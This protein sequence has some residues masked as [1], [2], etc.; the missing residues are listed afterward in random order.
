TVAAGSRRTG[1]THPTVAGSSACC[2]AACSAAARPHLLPRFPQ[3]PRHPRTD[4]DMDKES[5]D[6]VVVGAGSAGSVIA[7]RLSADPFVRVCLVEAGGP[8]TSSLIHAPSGLVVMMRSKINNWALETV[9][10]PGLNG[11]TGYQPRGKTL[12]GSSS[13]NGMV[14][15]RGHR[16]DYDHWASLGNDGW[17]FSQVLPY[18]RRAENSEVYGEN[19]YHG[20]GGPLNVT[21][22]RND[23]PRNRLCIAACASQGIHETADYNGANQ[24]GAFRYQVTHKNGERCSAAKAYLT[25]VLTRPNLDVRTHAV[26]ASII[27]EQK[28]ACGVRYYQD[29]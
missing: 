26:S 1:S 21:T 22:S 29:N 9:P 24:F 8:D 10:Q 27:I 20:S 12:G 6:Y 15:V 16:W 17:S 23:R 11:R 28:R 4:Q 13:I 25:P 3:S 7:V 5:F 19:D 14:Y 2:C 18:F